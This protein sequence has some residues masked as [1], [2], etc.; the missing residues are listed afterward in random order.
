MTARLLD[1]TAEEYHADPCETPSI[2]ASVA[3]KIITTSPWHA[4]HDHRRLNPDYTPTADTKFDVGTIAHAILLEGK[5]I[6]QAVDAPDWRTNAAKEERDA[7]RAAG[8]VPLLTSQVD[9]VEAMVDAARSQ[10]CAYDPE[11]F[12]AGKPEQAIVWEEDGVHCRALLDWLTDDRLCIQDMK[13][14]SR[15]ADPHVFARSI[16]GLGYDLKAAWYIRAVESLTGTPPDFL[17]VALETTPPYALS[18]VR[19]S[20]ALLTIGRKKCQYALNLWRR[21]LQEDRWPGYP[22]EVV[23]AELMPWDEEKW[24]AKEVAIEMAT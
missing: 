14:T 10:L 9:E 17:W 16:C 7:A 19:P 4:W 1:L 2:S 12:T 23:T 21:C 11:P 6:V 5:D 20:S 22:S 15:S 3:H 13:T 8:K 18:V 24:L